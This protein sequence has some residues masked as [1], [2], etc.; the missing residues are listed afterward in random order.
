MVRYHNVLGTSEVRY[1]S[2]GTDNITVEFSNGSIYLYTYNSTSIEEIEHMKNLAEQGGGLNYFIA[3]KVK[4][5]YEA[6]LC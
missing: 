2:N 3:T 4:N 1:Y 5:R 6:R